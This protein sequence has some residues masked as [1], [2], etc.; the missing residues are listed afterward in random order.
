MNEFQKIVKYCAMAFAAFLAFTIITGIVTALLA[1]TGLLSDSTGA[2]AEINKSFDNVK[3]LNI[4]HEVGTLN[5]KQGNGNEVVVEAA[6]VN[7][8]IKIEK[9]LSGELKIKNN[10]RFWNIFNGGIGSNSVITIYVPQDFI[11]DK[12]KLEAG[13]GNI[14]IEDIQTQ[15]LDLEAGVGD[16]FG[17]RIKADQV[18]MDGGV[19]DIYF[20]DVNFNDID[21]DSGV[22]DIEVQGFLYGKNKI[23]CGVGD[24][25][26]DLAQTVDD[27]NLKV[28]KGLGSI[29]VDGK[30]YSDINW[31]NIT[32]EN[33]LKIS[34][35]IGDI[36]I[37]F[38]E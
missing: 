10:F 1:I 36:E 2:R 27:Y 32:A 22:G 28:N 5:I 30:K 8:N 16:I 15:E 14:N 7:D 11:V 38:D 17:K 18:K 6:N 29:Y 33:T 26:L 31:N 35:G 3:S 37:N 25:T 19:G 4:E 13:A 23:D 34:G 12:V 24:I 9:N 21:I 20:E